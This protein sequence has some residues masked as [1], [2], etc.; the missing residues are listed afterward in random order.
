MLNKKD[1]KQNKLI[2]EN[3]KSESAKCKHECW[4]KVAFYP[5]V[6]VASFKNIYTVLKVT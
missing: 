6:F 4:F 2:C 5:M 1:G 3:K